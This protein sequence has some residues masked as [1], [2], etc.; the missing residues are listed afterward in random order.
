MTG[1]CYYKNADNFILNE[2]LDSI[3]ENT[4]DSSLLIEQSSKFSPESADELIQEAIN[5]K[6]DNL[7]FLTEDKNINILSELI[8]QEYGNKF[9]SIQVLSENFI[10]YNEDDLTAN[11]APV[12]NVQA[13]NMPQQQQ[14]IKSVV[15][16]IC[17]AAAPNAERI[18]NF[19]QF[20][21]TAKQNLA[22]YGINDSN[23]K[24]IKIW[25]SNVDSAGL[26]ASGVKTLYQK[27]PGGLFSKNDSFSNMGFTDDGWDGSVSDVVAKAM[28]S[29][30]YQSG[31]SYYFIIPQ[32]LKAVQPNDPN[33]RV[34]II[35]INNTWANKNNNKILNCII[36]LSKDAKDNF[37]NIKKRTDIKQ[38]SEEFAKRINKDKEK[39][40]YIET[41]VE[42][43]NWFEK[44][45]NEVRISK[46]AESELEKA[47]KEWLAQGFE[48]NAWKE[49]GEEIGLGIVMS[50]ISKISNALKKDDTNTPEKTRDEKQNG[51]RLANIFMYYNYENLCK[52]LFD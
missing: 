11:Q 9:K 12:N 15:V 50:G 16:F 37:A 24:E 46:E 7:V 17:D 30:T 49:K 5:K 31:G 39:I 27:Y 1:I 40:E 26:T 47:L 44:H 38:G 36:E 33:Q 22:S 20:V 2:Q 52:M 45:K 41:Y 14:K 10:R 21:N 34:K 23:E 29:K 32:N 4:E 42:L 18:Q 19:S 6:C 51:N 35:N 25:F 48:L 8:P 3:V 13:N 28:T 43:F